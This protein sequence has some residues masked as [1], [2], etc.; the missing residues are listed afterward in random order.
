[1]TLLFVLI[2]TLAASDGTAYSCGYNDYG[3]IGL[4]S[5]AVYVTTPTIL[6]LTGVSLN[7]VATREDYSLV[8][9]ENWVDINT[10]LLVCCFFLVK[11]SDETGAVVLLL[12][13]ITLPTLF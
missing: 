3:Q 7:A 1:M 8:L 4:A 12:T 11:R 9:G 6:P 2:S 10:C 5:S 13:Y